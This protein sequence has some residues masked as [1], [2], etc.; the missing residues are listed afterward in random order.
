MQFSGSSLFT[1]MGTC[2]RWPERGAIRVVD[3]G[4]KLGLIGGVKLTIRI[5]L[6]IAVSHDCT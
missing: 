1:T 5:S 6:T 2:Y 3:Q 4:N